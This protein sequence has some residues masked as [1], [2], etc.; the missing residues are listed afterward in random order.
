MLH[1]STEYNGLSIN[2][3]KQAPFWGKIWKTYF[4]CDWHFFTP[5][6]SLIS[7]EFSRAE[8][9]VAWLMMCHT[10]INENVIYGFPPM[11]PTVA[12]VLL[13][14]LTLLIIQYRFI[15]IL[16]KVT[17]THNKLHPSEYC[18]FT[19]FLLV[20]LD[21]PQGCCKLFSQSNLQI[22]FEL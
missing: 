17:I 2:K 15:F 5:V 6:P 1:L 11:V 9:A 21:L 16:P 4:E 19:T 14:F 12:P 7:M 20:V 22:T 10:F 8:C 3:I 13:L 18:G